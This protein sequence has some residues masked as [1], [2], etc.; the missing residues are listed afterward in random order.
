MHAH[1]GGTVTA[2]I[3]A[4]QGEYTVVGRAVFPEFGDTGQLGTGAWTTVA[5]VRR[6]LPS[7]PRDVFYVRYAPSADRNARVSELVSVMEPLPSRNDARPEDL[8]DL[9]RGGGLMFVLV[10]L[11]ALL[12]IAL[13]VH[14]LVTSVRTSRQF[15]ATLRAIGLTRRESQ[16]I[17]LSQSCALAGLAALIGIPLGLAAGRIAWT[18]YADHLGVAADA[19]TP[20]S[21]VLAGGA[22]ALGAAIVGAI[23]PGWLVRRGRTAETLRVA[24]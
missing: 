15:H 23:L 2:N 18:A 20:I 12:S 19:F 8:V 9:A 10:A 22:V 4:T 17:V 6:L 7:A 13:L 21:A 3:G 11:L 5:G 14:A 1:V 24:E 16:A